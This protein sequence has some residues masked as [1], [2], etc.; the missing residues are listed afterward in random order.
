M[1]RADMAITRMP[2]ETNLEKLARARNRDG[3]RNQ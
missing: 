3:G 2:K 1:K